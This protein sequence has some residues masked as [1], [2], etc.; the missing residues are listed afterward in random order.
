MK[1]ILLRAM[2]YCRNHFVKASQKAELQ[3]SNQL[4]KGV[5]TG[6]AKAGQYILIRNS[7]LNDELYKIESVSEAEG[8]VMV[9]DDLQEEQIT[10]IVYFL[11]IPQGF[12]NVCKKVAELENKHTG[13]ITSEKFG[14]Y[15][16]SYDNAGTEK[17]MQNGLKPYVRIF[18]DIGDG[19]C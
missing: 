3:L 14:D 1:D 8:G 15:S 19:T 17:L 5:H 9:A 6:I 18:N 10:A 12:I 16:V 4:I 11:A 2:A 7:Y 13:N